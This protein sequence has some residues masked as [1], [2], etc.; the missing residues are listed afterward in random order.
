MAELKA[1]AN[2]TAAAPDEPVPEY[3]DLLAEEVNP[4]TIPPSAPF[5]H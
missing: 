3:N 4:E 2:A 1:K 5:R